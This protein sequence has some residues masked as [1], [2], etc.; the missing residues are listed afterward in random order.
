MVREHSLCSSYP[1]RVWLTSVPQSSQKLRHGETD[2]DSSFSSTPIICSY[3]WVKKCRTL[4]CWFGFWPVFQ[5]T[6]L[7]F[8]FISCLPFSPHPIPTLTQVLNL[9]LA[10][11]LSSFSSD[12]LTAIEEDTDA[13]NLQTAVARIKKGINYVKQT[14]R[15]FFLKAFSTK[16]KISK[17]IRRTEDRSVFR[18]SLTF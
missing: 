13:N 5:K 18:Y 2:E 8:V 4:R 14:L 9:F 17:E 15:E 3:L 10:L 16:P 12:N 7:I 6:A 1:L 11:L